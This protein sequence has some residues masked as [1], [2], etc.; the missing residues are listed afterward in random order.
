MHL[1]EMLFDPL[2]PSLAAE[3]GIKMWDRERQRCKSWV[4]QA[5]FASC[6]VFPTSV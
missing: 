3:E 6:T 2:Y 4:E 5:E 1:G